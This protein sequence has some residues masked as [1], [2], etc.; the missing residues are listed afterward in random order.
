[1]TLPVTLLV[2]QCPG[3]AV[4]EPLE[5]TPPLGQG[6]QGKALPVPEVPLLTDDRSARA[7]TRAPE[8]SSS[9]ITALP[10]TAKLEAA[11]TAVIELLAAHH[12]IHLGG[13]MPQ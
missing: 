3:D 2:P 9:T 12:N 6:K 13:M 8:G 5:H 4:T 1:M 7:W 10:V 11:A